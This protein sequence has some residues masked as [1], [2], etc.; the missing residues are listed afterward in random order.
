MNQRSVPRLLAVVFIFVALGVVVPASSASASS[1]SSGNLAYIVLPVVPNYVESAPGPDN[2]PINSSNIATIFSGDT[3]AQRA[4]V[5]QQFANGQLSGYIRVFRSQVQSGDGVV[6]YAFEAPSVYSISTF[7]GGFEEAAASQVTETHGSTFAIPGVPEGNGYDSYVASGDPPFRD[8]VVAFAKGNIA[9][10]LTLVTPWNDL[11]KANAISLAQRQ[12]T[13]APETAVAPQTPP[14][15]AED[16]LFGVV[17]A[18]AVALIG[19]AWTTMRRRRRLSEDPSLEDSN[20]ERYKS[21]AKDQRKIARKMM[22]KS[23]LNEDNALNSAAVAWANRN[24]NIY[25]VTLAALVAFSATVSIVSQGHVYVVSF[26][27]IAC[28]VG[29]LRLRSQRKQF[30]EMRQRPQDPGAPRQIT[31][32]TH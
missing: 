6:E 14:S 19:I 7:L 1:S 21:L 32:E 3:A 28:L 26:L 11:T 9:F 29:A 17:A 18:M 27:A 24:I 13:L 15:V 16:L 20:Y 31:V 23:R 4:L 25:W 30:I 8:F 12:W 10:V 22:T 5:S 2:G